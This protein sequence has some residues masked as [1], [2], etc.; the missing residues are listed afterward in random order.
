MVRKSTILF[1]NAFFDMFCNIEGG[2]TS[3][4]PIEQLRLKF[5]YFENNNHPGKIFSSE[6]NFPEIYGDRFDDIVLTVA[7]KIYTLI[8]ILAFTQDRELVIIIASYYDNLFKTTR[9]TRTNSD[10][11]PESGPDAEPESEPKPSSRSRLNAP[12]SEM[13]LEPIKNEVEANE[14]HVDEN[15]YI[16][17]IQLDEL[18]LI[19]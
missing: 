12:I 19:G 4:S 3:I 14:V 2:K 1:A 7:R 9:T 15:D 6:Y 10:V 5:T 18:D 17:T 8:P 13:K 16:E 11:E